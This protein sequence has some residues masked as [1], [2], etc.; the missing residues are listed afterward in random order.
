[1]ATSDVATG[2]SFL[3]IFLL[4][5]YYLPAITIMVVYECKL[6]LAHFCVFCCGYI[7]NQLQQCGYKNVSFLGTL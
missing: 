6:P 7:P 1:M 2:V 3:I 4:L 5:K